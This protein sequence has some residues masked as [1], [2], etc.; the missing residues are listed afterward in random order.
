[1]GGIDLVA[2]LF[3]HGRRREWY[4]KFMLVT[5]LT[6]APMR[7]VVLSDPCFLF[8][9]RNHSSNSLGCSKGSCF[10]F[11]RR[12][13]IGAFLRFIL[14]TCWGHSDTFFFVFEFCFATARPCGYL[15][16]PS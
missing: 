13:R 1:M 15:L 12:P 11:R 8:S 5:I 14:G 10:R 9:L 2:G 16:C 3:A 4:I 6:R 7:R